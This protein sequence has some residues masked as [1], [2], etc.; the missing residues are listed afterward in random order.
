MA[1]F[2]PTGGEGNAQTIMFDIADGVLTLSFGEGGPVQG[3]TAMLRRPGG[4]E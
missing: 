1:R 3:S 4:G 2:A